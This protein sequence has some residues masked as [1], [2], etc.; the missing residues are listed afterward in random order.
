MQ[1]YNVLYTALPIFAYTL[2]DKDAE[3][4]DLIQN[5]DIYGL[6]NGNPTRKQRTNDDS[7]F[8]QWLL[9]F[10]GGD[11][12]HF[13]IFMRWIFESCALAGVITWF[14]HLSWAGLTSADKNWSNIRSP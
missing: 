13:R 4:I 10:D 9:D 3:D 14:T 11:K 8:R 5:P 2:F 7:S 6:T 12:F 1:C